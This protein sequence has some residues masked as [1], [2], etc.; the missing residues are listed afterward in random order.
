MYFKI[1]FFVILIGIVLQANQANGQG[2]DLFTYSSVHKVEERESYSIFYPNDLEEYAGIIVL[3]HSQQASNPK[4]YGD[5]IESF[6]RKGYVLIYPAY[7]DYVVSQNKTDLDFIASSLKSAEKD[8]MKNYDDVKK[9]QVAFIGHSM[10][11]IIV[12]ELASGKVEIPWKP[13]C[14]ISVCPAEVKS[15]KNE[16][17]NFKNMDPYALHLIIE[18][19]KD[20]FYKRGTGTAIL[21]GISDVERKK[22]VVH[23]RDEKGASKHMNFWSPNKVFSSKNNTFVTYFPKFIGETNEIDKD[24][25][26]VEIDKAL[27]CAF[28]RKNCDGFTK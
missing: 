5:F 4:V 18:E 14:V 20:K 21:K 16:D 3:I 25:Y 8:I 7:Q 24:F 9:L 15:H 2:K 23:S 11:G 26:W 28:S 19:E 1:L 27:E 12:Q 13:N 10:G 17:I 6:L 22:H